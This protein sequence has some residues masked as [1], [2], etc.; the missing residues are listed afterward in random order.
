MYREF[1]HL[2]FRESGRLP[3]VLAICA[4]TLAVAMLEGLNIGLLIPLLETL[5]S[6]DQESGHWISRGVSD[7]FAKL[8]IPFSLQYILLVLG[9]IVLVVAGLK[10]LRMIV[11]A[12]A[13][14]RFR[15]WFR[16]RNM[17]R[18][19]NADI[20]YFHGQQLGVLADSLT[21]QA[22][23]SGTSL[24]LVTE[25]LTSVGVIISYLLVAFL[26][27]PILTATAFGMLLVV[28]LSMQLFI[29][30]A[31]ALGIELFKRE[32]ELQASAVET[33]SAVHVIK[34]FLLENSRWMHFTG[35]ADAVAEKAFE[36][37]KVRSQMIVAQELALFGLI[38]LIIYIGVAVLNLGIAV[39]VA[40]LFTLY[41]LA[42]R[43]TALNAS[44]QALAT[45]VAALH[46][47]KL[48][49]EETETPRIV[50]GTRSYSGLQDSITVKDV[51]FGYN[52]IENV[53]HDTNFT[54]EKNRMTAIVGA[55]GAGKTTLM[56]LLLRYYDPVRGTILVDGVDLRELDLESWRKSIGVVSQDVFLFNDTVANNIALWRPEATKESV[57]EDAKQAYAHDF[58]QQMPE[59][60]E[61]SI[62][63]RGWNLSGGQRQ[64]LALARAIFSKPEVLILDEATS[65]LD[66]ESERFI[67]E[68]INAIRGTSTLV[69]VAHRMS[70]IQG[71]D[72]IVVLE[73]GKIVEEGDLNSLLAASGAFAKYYRLQFSGQEALI[74]P[75]S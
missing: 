31:K 69:V 34:S 56:D 21:T 73:D 1:W 26:I 35:K 53:L 12:R 60:Y 57:I 65:S 9:G 17:G 52:G 43:V 51:D 59:G 15:V 50:S 62:G 27:S 6:S 2:L 22:N 25:L 47:L 45:N 44:R 75:E 20:S 61:T 58:I 14:E 7:V 4:I 19:M 23:H 13:R 32:T 28:S 36:L 29:N 46:S 68:Y 8:G 3:T 40:L 54:I 5:G 70:T 38:G 39:I 49:M 24:Y 10:Y 74:T 42:P 33:L 41:R 30:S 67:Q 11:E 72:K 37:T 66:S 48:L 63:D 18:L 64:R 16:S 71:A 55:S